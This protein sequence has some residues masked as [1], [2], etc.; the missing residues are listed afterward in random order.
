MLPCFPHE[1]DRGALRVIRYSRIDSSYLRRA[2][3]ERSIIIPRA[4]SRA[5]ARNSIEE[6]LLDVVSTRHRRVIDAVNF[7]GRWN[8]DSNRDIRCIALNDIPD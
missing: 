6:S 7:M 8:G 2:Q 5:I 3:L 1:T 4:L